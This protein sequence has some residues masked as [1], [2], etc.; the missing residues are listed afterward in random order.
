MK[1]D[2]AVI[3]DILAAGWSRE[4]GPAEIAE[5]LP[6]AGLGDREPPLEGEGAAG[7]R[8]G[9]ALDNQVRQVEIGVVA[10]V[11][12]VIPRQVELAGAP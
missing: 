11:P 8:L 1:L 2:V 6:G 7:A 4:R 10:G 9:G 3:C 12:A 5:A